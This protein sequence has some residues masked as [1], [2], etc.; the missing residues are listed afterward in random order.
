MRV[1]TFKRGQSG[2][3]IG[4]IHGENIADMKVALEMS[5][6][7]GKEVSL[8]GVN[9]R[10][11]LQ[12]PN[13]MLELISLGDIGIKYIKQ[14]YEFLNNADEIEL[15]G[16]SSTSGDRVLYN[17]DKVQLLKPLQVFRALNVGANYNSYLAS[18]NIIEPYKG[19]VETFWKLP[20]TVIGP[21][22][23]IIWPLSSKQVCCEME[24]GVIIGKKTKRVTRENALDSVFGYTVVNDV[25][26]IDLIRRGLGP[27]R[28]GLPGFYYLCLAKSFDTFEP[29]GPCITLKD[30]IPDPQNL[31]SE[32]RINDELKVKGK[33][34]DMRLSVS[35]IIEFVSQDITLYPGDL[36]ATGAMATKEYAPQVNVKVG[37]NVEM[38]IE[39]IGIL[40]NSVSK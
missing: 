26:A 1:V 23:K 7:E 38:Q 6:L 39:R 12:I 15:L 17:K 40:R 3:K 28:E 32:Y 4:L 33:T 21:N 37:D 18:M 29:I 10:T 8:A 31:N 35:E 30:E 16:A 2:D 14:T 20:Q 19:T 22:E 24:L 5:L 27:G 36:I 11:N 13:S 25:T 34:S 9:K